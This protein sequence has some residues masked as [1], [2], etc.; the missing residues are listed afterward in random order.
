MTLFWYLRDKKKKKKSQIFK[1]D[2][3]IAT[4]VT[5]DPN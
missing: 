4:A 3:S 2:L 5:G 1:T